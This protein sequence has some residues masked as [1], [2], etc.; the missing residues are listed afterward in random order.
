MKISTVK[1]EKL[2]FITEMAD[3]DKL[4]KREQIVKEEYESLLYGFTVED[5]INESKNEKFIKNY[6]SYVCLFFR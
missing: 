2:L 1:Q 4:I 5:F 3:N 6:Y